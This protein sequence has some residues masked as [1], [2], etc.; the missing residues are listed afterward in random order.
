[1]SLKSLWRDS[2]LEKNFKL[3]H[4]NCEP[5]IDT[6]ERN[7][8]FKHARVSTNNIPRE[9]ELQRN[10]RREYVEKAFATGGLLLPVVGLPEHSDLT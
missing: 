7:K 5:N 10:N 4:K 8:P 9:N 3:R 2:V 6:S 1:M